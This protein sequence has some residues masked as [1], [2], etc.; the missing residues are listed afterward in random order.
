MKQKYVA[1]QQRAGAPIVLETE[2]EAYLA[3]M[4]V[5]PPLS[6]KYT[7]NNLVLALKSAG[8]WSKLDWLCLHAAHHE[9]AGRINL[10]Q[11]SEVAT[12]VNS[13]T[14]TVDTGYAGDGSTSYL[15]SG[16]NA[17]VGGPHAY[18]QNSAHAGL[19]VPSDIGGVASFDM[20]GLNGATGG[21]SVRT[22]ATSSSLARAR[23]TS[24]AVFDFT[25]P[26]ATA[27]GHSCCKRGSSTNID[28]Y[29]DG[30]FV[31]TGA[32]ASLAVADS[33][34]AICG[35]MSASAIAGYTNTPIAVSHWGSDLT[36]GELFDLASALHTYLSALGL[37]LPSVELPV[38]YETE[39]M[40][41]LSAM[42]VQPTLDRKA[43][44]D[45]FIVSL[46]TSGA[47]SKLDWLSLH[48]AH[49]EQAARV[50]M[51]NPAQVATAVNSPTFTIDVGFTG[52]GATSYLNTG[53]NSSSSG[54]L[55]LQNDCHMGVRVSDDADNVN[56]Y[57][58]GQY[59]SGINTRIGTNANIA[60]QS[61]S[62]VNLALSPATSVGHTAFSRTSSSAVRLYKDG[63]GSSVTLTSTARR[64]ASSLICAV[65]SSTT[66][67]LSPA[68]YSARTNNMF[69]FGGSLTDAEMLSINDAYDTYVAAL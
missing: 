42:S 68:G 52:D 67:G 7:I 12:A 55:Y 33:T 25:L 26:S 56:Y 17:A 1:Q 54:G 48:A 2:T 35:L 28:M 51:K 43:A 16:W 31:Q 20:G 50:N 44:I 14:F 58:G 46:K 24:S 22:R 40:A 53:V 30:A 37:T 47:W 65:N 3:A 29:K 69:H 5:Q 4:T 27:L 6:R 59:T 9:Q 57:D 45:A 63:V 39:T 41:Y 49:H 34:V 61:S 19:Y 60:I 23:L 66:G 21:M 11:P 8:L 62:N 15:N 10:V 32:V 13:P 64:N 18:T 36:V 38:S